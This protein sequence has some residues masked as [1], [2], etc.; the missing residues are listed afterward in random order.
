MLGFNLQGTTF[1]LKEFDYS[2]GR[3]I[4]YEDVV[5]G[6][7]FYRPFYEFTGTRGLPGI[8]D[9]EFARGYIMRTI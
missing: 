9:I 8:M 2:Y 6:L 7:I 1:G 4:K 3:N 5:D